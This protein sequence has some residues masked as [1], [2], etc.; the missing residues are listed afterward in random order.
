MLLDLDITPSLQERIDRYGDFPS[1]EYVIYLEKVFKEK[2][3]AEKEK[4]YE[5]EVL[6]IV[7]EL[8]RGL[9]E[10]RKHLVIT[11]GYPVGHS[12]P[13]RQALVDDLRLFINKKINCRGW[14][15]DSLNISWH[16]T[17]YLDVTPL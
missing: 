17:C 8:K 2:A 4:L 1:P 7:D 11:F 13:E 12:I 9:W 5:P 3:L 10:G 6:K 15:I 14:K 16:Q